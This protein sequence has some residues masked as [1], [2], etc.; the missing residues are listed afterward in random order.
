MKMVPVDIKDLPRIENVSVWVSVKEKDTSCAFNPNLSTKE[1]M[2]AVL[3][4]ID[5]A[6]MHIT[7]QG[8]SCNTCTLAKADLR[9]MLTTIGMDDK[10]ER[11]IN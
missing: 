2:Y 3:T 7:E 9:K 6:I 5:S 4:V 10:D 1:I 11:T 8:C